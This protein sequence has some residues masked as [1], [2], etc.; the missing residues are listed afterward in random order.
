MVA[1]IVVL[2]TFKDGYEADFAEYSQKVRSFLKRQ[3]AVVVRR[4]LIKRT[5]S[6][7]T[8]PSLVMLIDF[9]S[10]DSAESC[11]DKQEYLDL[12]PLRARVFSDF[13]MY[14]AMHGEV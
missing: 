3:D 13:Q 6:G 9:P 5:L 12:I 8:R 4:Q 7:D 14:L 10:N 11:F 1:T 2:G